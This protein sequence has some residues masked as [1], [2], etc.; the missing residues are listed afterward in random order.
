MTHKR[1]SHARVVKTE[2][3]TNDYLEL[4]LRIREQDAKLFTTLSPA[5]IQSVNI[6]TANKRK[7]EQEQAMRNEAA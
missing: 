2:H 7:F 1:A 4:L 5:L 6:Y 3:A